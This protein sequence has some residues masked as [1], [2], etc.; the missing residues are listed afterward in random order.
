[1]SHSARKS[2]MNLKV[3]FEKDKNK[4]KKQTSKQ[5]KQ[6]NKKQRNKMGFILQSELLPA[7]PRGI[8]LF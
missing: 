5:T 7:E 3:N 4:N 1:M 8:R 2:T 6:T